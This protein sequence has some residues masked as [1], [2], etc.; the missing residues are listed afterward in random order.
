[1][2]K[3]VT[4]GS[5]FTG[6]ARTSGS[7]HGP[8]LATR[9]RAED[10]DEAEREQN[11]M[12]PMQP[13]EGRDRRLCSPFAEASMQNER[14]RHEQGERE[15][16]P[17][18]D[19]RVHPPELRRLE[20]FPQIESSHHVEARQADDDDGRPCLPHE[21]ALDR[22]EG[23]EPIGAKITAPDRRQYH[24]GRH[25]HAADPDHHSEDMQSP[26]DHD[27]IHGYSPIVG[28]GVSDAEATFVAAERPWFGRRPCWRQ[29]SRRRYR[30]KLDA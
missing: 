22:L 10:R 28:N 15:Q 4:L 7:E 5:D 24:G 19:H 29:P 14:L 27:I 12:R 6:S 26:R 8:S 11:P 16:Q 20:P 1:M 9:D 18:A 13:R 17:Y 30:A 21:A 25:P 23:P 2:S 3:G